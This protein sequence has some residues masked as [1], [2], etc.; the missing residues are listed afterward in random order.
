ML[1]LHIDNVHSS[2][3]NSNSEY[4]IEASKDQTV[5]INDI[6][7]TIDNSN[8]ELVI[9]IF[10]SILLIFIY[11]TYQILLFHL[12]NHH[13]HHHLVLVFHLLEDQVTTHKILRNAPSHMPNK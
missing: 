6:P 12:T 9:I 7:T 13:Q 5:E 10:I 1:P 4:A 11:R 2:N 8:F 3:A